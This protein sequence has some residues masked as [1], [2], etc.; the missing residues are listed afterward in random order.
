MIAAMC[1]HMSQ[2]FLARHPSLTAV[3]EGKVYLLFKLFRCDLRQVAKI[4]SVGFPDSRCEVG[5]RRRLLRPAL[6]IGM[7]FPY[8]IGGENPIDDMRVIENAKGG[9]Q[10]FGWGLARQGG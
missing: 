9:M 8:E 1:D 3:G 10:V 2:H 6:L 5:Q 4:P 7:G